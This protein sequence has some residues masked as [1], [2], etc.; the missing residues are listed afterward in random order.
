MLKPV[1]KKLMHRQNLSLEEVKSAIEAIITGADER[2]TA[3]FLVLLRSKGETTEELTGF[4]KGMLKH[5]IKIGIDKKLMDIV[6]T[7]G[8]NAH[9]VNISTASSILAA[10][11]GVIVAK[12]GNRS[13]TSKCSSAEL[14]QQLGV[15]LEGDPKV[16][17]QCIKKANIAFLYAPFYH[18]AFK[19][20]ASIRRALMVRTTFNILGPLLN[21]AKVQYLLL[22]VFDPKLLDLMAQTLHALGVQKAWVVYCKGLDELAPIGPADIR[23]VTPNGVTEQKLEAM[24]FGLKRC[25]IE[26]LKGGDPI[27]NAA[28]LTE[29]FQGKRGPIAD[30]LVLNAGAALYIYGLVEDI[31]KGIKIARSALEDGNAYQ[32]LINWKECSHP[33]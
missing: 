12:H 26:D 16:V 9:T 21:P 11:C 32:T 10:S 6:G 7:G 24:D 29:V 3:A 13:V 4:V 20:V 27:E 23:E 15:K 8:D 31:G 30:T 14:V 18:P 2:Q 17:I 33:G 28:I 19:A 5:A 25:T 22:G 1:I